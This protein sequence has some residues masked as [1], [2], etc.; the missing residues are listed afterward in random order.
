VKEKREEKTR[1]NDEKYT[2]AP[3]VCAH[4]V[5]KT[6]GARAMMREELY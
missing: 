6:A 2:S 5:F 4:D 3:H 1:E